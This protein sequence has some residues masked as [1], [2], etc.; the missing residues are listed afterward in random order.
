[1]LINGSSSNLKK[2][3]GELPQGSALGL[4]LFN[5]LINDLEEGAEGMLMKLAGDTKRG[6]V[7][8]ATEVKIGMQHDLNKLENWAKTNKKD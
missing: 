8:N 5:I 6:E 4:V 7:A 1:M 3:T 2:V